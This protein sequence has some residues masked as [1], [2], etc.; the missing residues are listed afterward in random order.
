MAQRK[1]DPANPIDK[2]AD[3]A[4]HALS[5]GETLEDCLSA[6]IAAAARQFQVRFRFIRPA[7]FVVGHNEYAWPA[8]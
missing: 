7:K 8:E 1:P 3:A 2:V 6:V 5:A 4:A